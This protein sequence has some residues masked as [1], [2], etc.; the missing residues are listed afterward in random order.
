MRLQ[1]THSALLGLLQL[2]TVEQLCKSRQLINLWLL[3]T[4]LPACYDSR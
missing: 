3:R 1:Q 4:H 2:P